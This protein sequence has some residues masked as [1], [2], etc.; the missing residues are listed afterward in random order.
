M[1]FKGILPI[2]TIIIGIFLACIALIWLD[3]ETT[4]WDQVFN[5]NMLNAGLLYGLPALLVVSLIYS[6]L[7]KRIAMWPS[8]IAALI[9]GIPVSFV[10]III[11]LKISSLF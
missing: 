5:S 2:A 3:H 10:T 6:W 4:S 11:V 7:K 1:K 9:L 8:A